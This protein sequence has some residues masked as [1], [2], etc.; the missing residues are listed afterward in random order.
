MLIIL[1]YEMKNLHMCIQS[2]SVIF[3]FDFDND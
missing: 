1:Y 3:L 2:F